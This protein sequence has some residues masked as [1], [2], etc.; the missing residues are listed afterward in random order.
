[1]VFVGKNSTWRALV[2]ST[3]FL[4]SGSF[5][6]KWAGPLLDT[7]NTPSGATLLRGGYD[8]SIWGYQDGGIFTRTMI[9]LSDN[10][11]LGVSFDT[12]ELIGNGNIKFNTPG[13]IARIKLTDQ[14]GDMPLLIAAGYEPW[15]VPAFDTAGLPSMTSSRFLY[16]PYLVFTKPIFL[17][18][19]EQHI[20]LGLRMPLQPYYAPQDTSLFISFD[21]P[22]GN[23]IPMFEI[24]RIYFDGS[25]LRYV[26]WN[27][28]FR[29]NLFDTFGIELNIVLDENGLVDRFLGFEYAGMF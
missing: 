29:L 15:L 20:H 26:L 18:E 3:L 28:G 13:V 21:F 4:F 9:G 24:D 11:M 17:M 5:S 6:G 14:I 12:E 10:I 19:S 2:L 8:I 1:M 25:R 22:L 27:F 23:F 16:G 7:V